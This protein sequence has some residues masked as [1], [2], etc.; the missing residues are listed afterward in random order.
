ML[1][2]GSIVGPLQ[3]SVHRRLDDLTRSA[4]VSDARQAA[5]LGRQDLLLL[6][7]ALRTVLAMHE[8]DA[9]GRCPVCQARGTRLPFRRRGRMPC[10]AYLAVQLRLG[11]VEA[12]VAAHTRHTRRRRAA[13][14]HSVG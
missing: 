11:T 7:E 14:L 3:A 5:R 9:R 8:P 2:H 4:D 12:P 1:E 6:I 13:A 10:H